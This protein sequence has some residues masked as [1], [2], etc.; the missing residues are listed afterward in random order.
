MKYVPGSFK[1]LYERP[2]GQQLWPFLL[3]PEN[4]AHMTTATRLGRPAAEG[5][6]EVLL[7]RFGD[8]VFED[9]V[10][11][12]I[13]HMIRQIMEANDYVIDM[14]NVKM[15]GYPFARATRYVRRGE[16][17]YYLWHKGADARAM[18]VTTDVAG[19]R[20][21]RSAEESWHYVGAV[22][23]ELRAVVAFGMPRAVEVDSAL[24]RDGWLPYRRE[25]IVK[26]AA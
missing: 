2:L 11:Q 12:M 15:G 23:G 24:D 13:G 21:P 1:D 25:R 5:L 20:L 17:T 9:R 10:K 14:Q 4:V 18:A 19:S 7:D 22:R 6:E 8:V 16:R 3:L 26:K